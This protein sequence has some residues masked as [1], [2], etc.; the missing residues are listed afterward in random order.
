LNWCCSQENYRCCLYNW[1]CS[2]RYFNILEAHERLLPPAGGIRPHVLHIFHR[3]LDKDCA[4]LFSGLFHSLLNTTVMFAG[5]FDTCNLSFDTAP[6]TSQVIFLL[7]VFL[8][9]I[10]LLNLLNGLAVG[11]TEEIRKNGDTLSLVARVKLISK[12]ETVLYALPTFKMPEKFRSVNIVLYPN[13]ENSIEP[14]AIRSLLRIITNRRRPYKKS[15]SIVRQENCS[16]LTE[17]LMALEKRLLLKV[18]EET[19]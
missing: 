5:E 3:K 1:R 15:K 12:I 13:C 14:T 11:D 9:A 6:Y 8:V 19:Q 2:A 16:L 7:F 18:E 17:K 10:I 4:D